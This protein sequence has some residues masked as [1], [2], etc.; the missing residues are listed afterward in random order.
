MRVQVRTGRPTKRD[1]ALL[2]RRDREEFE[3]RYSAL[4]SCVSALHKRTADPQ[5]LVERFNGELKALS[6]TSRP[7]PRKNGS[8]SRSAAKSEAIGD[9]LLQ[10]KRRTALR[11][12]AAIIAAE[13]DDAE[14][15]I[16]QLQFEILRLSL[17]QDPIDRYQRDLME[18]F[19]S[20][21]LSRQVAQM[22]G[23]GQIADFVSHVVMAAESRKSEAAQAITKDDAQQRQEWRKLLEDPPLVSVTRE[24]RASSDPELIKL[25][26]YGL[27]PFSMIESYLGHSKYVQAFH[28]AGPKDKSKIARKVLADWGRKQLYGSRPSDAQRHLWATMLGVKYGFAQELVKREVSVP[29]PWL[30]NEIVILRPMSS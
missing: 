4:E 9:Y 28:S 15:E 20:A 27:P 17:E 24:E 5:L 10:S 21:G 6:E 2:E 16:Q 3:A 8:T 13:C 12:M 26:K 18:K 22:I 29:S 14:V 25:H 11:K 7:A 1:R 19:N 23:E 30:A